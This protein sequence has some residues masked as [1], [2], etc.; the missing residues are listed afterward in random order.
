MFAASERK[1]GARPTRSYN[2]R[3]R[4]IALAKPMKGTEG[5]RWRFSIGIVFVDFLRTELDRVGPGH[6]DLCR[7]LFSRAV[8]LE[9]SFFEAA[10]TT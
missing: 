9:L 2:S 6:E 7:D 3:A 5:L 1:S 8:A 4:T 10:Y